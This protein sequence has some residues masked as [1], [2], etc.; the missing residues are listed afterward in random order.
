MKHSPAT[1]KFLI[2]FISNINIFSS[3]HSLPETPESPRHRQASSLHVARWSHRS[4]DLRWGR[5]HPPLTQHQEGCYLTAADRTEAFHSGDD[6]FWFTSCTCNKNRVDL[7]I[8][9]KNVSLLFF[10]FHKSWGTLSCQ[11][12]PRLIHVF[13]REQIKMNIY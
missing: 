10:A 8:F 4:W 2:I 13:Y 9:E 1:Q 12:S 3:S 7:M 5:R 11:I 6:H